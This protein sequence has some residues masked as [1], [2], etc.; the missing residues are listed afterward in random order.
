M[1]VVSIKRYEHRKDIRT[2]IRTT[3]QRNTRVT[4]AASVERVA[5]FTYPV[6]LS[7]LRLVHRKNLT[8]L[9]PPQMVAPDASRVRP[10]ISNALAN[11]NVR[12]S[13]IKVHH[14]HLTEMKHLHLTKL[15]YTLPANIA[16]ASGR[17]RRSASQEMSNK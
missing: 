8:N 4:T 2:D 15:L 6:R 11:C 3:K 14:L 12:V 7:L 1:L 9:Q 13:T 16:A 17:L 5:L 10:Q